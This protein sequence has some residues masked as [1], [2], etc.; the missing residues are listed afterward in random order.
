MIDNYAPG[1]G[2][3]APPDELAALRARLEESNEPL[4]LRQAEILG[5]R[6]RL[7][8]EVDAD[9]APKVADA[10]KVC[11][12]FAK[13]TDA[14][15]VAA[16][17]PHLAAG[18]AVDGFYKKLAEPVE[19]LKSDLSKLLTT[20]QR[21]VEA[22]ERR[23]REEAARAAEQARLEEER[24]RRAAEA[25]A[26]EAQR[27]AEEAERKKAEA[28]EA[29]RNASTLAA[30]EAAA[31]ARMEAEE[32]EAAAERAKA[33]VAQQTADAAGAKVEA[34]AAKDAAIE[35]PAELTRTR[36][37]LGS[38]ASLVRHWDFEVVDDQQ[39]PRM[40]LCVDEKA[41]R[42][43]IKVSTDKKT[44]ACRAKI[45]GIKLVEKFDSRVA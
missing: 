28:E 40:F 20:Y 26:K 29:A 9:T 41:V 19:E 23:L 17:E 8:A 35:K 22:E 3:N 33:K 5:M 39:V 21:K 42:A 1:I 11:A 44:G 25:A 34:Q 30:K 6:A 14:A 24:K 7:P 31:K 32:A 18:R 43:Y 13:N 38:V 37:D 4:A 10:I 2:H 16:K 15:R 27:Q 36:T 45:P 12:T